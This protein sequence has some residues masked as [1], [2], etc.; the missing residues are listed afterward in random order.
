MPFILNLI[1]ALW[2]AAAALTFAPFVWLV[3]GGGAGS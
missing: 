1:T 3:Y 2:C